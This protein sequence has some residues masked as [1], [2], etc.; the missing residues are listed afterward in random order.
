MLRQ[1]CTLLP[2]RLDG[3][4]ICYLFCKESTRL[5]FKMNEFPIPEDYGL[6]N[7]RRQSRGYYFPGRI[8]GANNANLRIAYGWTPGRK[9]SD[10]VRI[11]IAGDPLME[12]CQVLTN[13]LNASGVKWFY[14]CNANGAKLSRGYFHSDAV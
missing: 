1:S 2:R 4:G 13:L 14:L 5:H 6:D 10:K 12:T 8:G 3:T 11:R 7:P 9:S